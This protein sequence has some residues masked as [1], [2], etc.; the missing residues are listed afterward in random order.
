MDR[1]KE[2]KQSFDQPQIRKIASSNNCRYL[3]ILHNNSLYL[4]KEFKE[5]K[6][7]YYEICEELDQVK[8]SM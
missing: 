4:A 1:N 3:Y 7:A 5:L 6:T 2:N 8:L